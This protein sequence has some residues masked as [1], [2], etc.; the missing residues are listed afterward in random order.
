MK[1]AELHRTPQDNVKSIALIGGGIASIC[2]IIELFKAKPDLNITLYCK[3]EKLG[4]AAS[5][6]KQG[7][8]YPHLQGSKSPLAEINSRCYKYAKYF[9]KEVLGLGIEFDHQWCGVLQQAHTPELELRFEKVASVWPDDAEFIDEYQSSLFAGMETPFPSLWY[10]DGGWLAPFQLCE[11]A[12]E[13]LPQKF[14]LKIINNAHIKEVKKQG[15]NWR[16]VGSD[17]SIEETVDVV[18][19]CSGFSSNEFTPTSDLP[20][21]PIRGQVSRFH[22]STIMSSLKTVLCHKGYITPAQSQYQCF[23]ATFDKGNKTQQIKK[24][25]ESANFEQLEQMYASMSWSKDLA[26]EDIIGNKAGVR[27]N[28][29]DHLPIAGPVYPN[30]WVKN[31]VDQNNGL[32]K[33]KGKLPFKDDQG[34]PCYQKNAYQGIYTLTGLGARGLTTAPLLAKHVTEQIL[35]LPATLSDRLVC[36]ISPLRYQI[37]ELKRNKASR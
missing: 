30:D 28:S 22:S 21:E 2:L 19:I 32:L 5:G 37:R 14:A 13:T 6:N 34:E 24:E 11:S 33:R 23:G 31:N 26:R 20:L 25:D 36:A 35:D 8:I 12:S 17:Q 10:K 7:A 3:D 4:M 18:C 15:K 1:K 9:Y 27:A 29:P 16:L